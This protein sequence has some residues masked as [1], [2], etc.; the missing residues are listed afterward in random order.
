[1]YVFAIYIAIYAYLILA[2]GLTSR[3]TNTNIGVLSFIFGL[4]FFKRLINSIKQHFI[5]ISHLFKLIKKDWLIFMIM[6][7]IVIQA[8]INLV[9][10]LGP[11]LSFDSLWYHLTLPK[12]YLEQQRVYFLQ[13]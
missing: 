7:L 9:G 5:Q 12:L 13:G 1:M 10:A 2:L 11:E 3:L 4:I 6:L 8:L